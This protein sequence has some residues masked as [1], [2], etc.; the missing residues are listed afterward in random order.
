MGRPLGSKNKPRSQSE[1]SSRPKKRVNPAPA[2]T[3][4]ESEPAPPF[5]EDLNERDRF[6]YVPDTR[7]ARRPIALLPSDSPP[8]PRRY[9]ILDRI[10]LPN[11][12][13]EYILREDVANS[14]QGESLDSPQSQTTPSLISD[15]KQTSPLDS[16]TRSHTSASP[17]STLPHL[18]YDPDD[19]SLLRI[20]LLSIDRYVSQ[21]EVET[22]ENQ[23]FA[24]PKPED[25]P[26]ANRR[27]DTSSQGSSSSGRRSARPQEQV[28][29]K[30][31]VGRP[32]KKRRLME[33]VVINNA[34]GMSSLGGSTISGSEE[35]D[36]LAVGESSGSRDMDG[37]VDMLESIEHVNSDSVSE[38]EVENAVQ[39]FLPERPAAPQ[40]RR[41]P[42]S[43]S[44]R[45]SMA[46]PASRR[47]PIVRRISDFNQSPSPGKNT[48]SRATSYASAQ[49]SIQLS[50]SQSAGSLDN[51]ALKTSL[52][53]SP[54][55]PVVKVQKPM[56]GKIPPPQVEKTTVDSAK[57]L[58]REQFGGQSSHSPRSRLHPESPKRVSKPPPSLNQQAFERASMSNPARTF[59]QS[60]LNFPKA[61][62]AKPKSPEKPKSP[63]PKAKS[64][65]L[66]LFVQQDEDDAEEE[67]P[68]YE[69]SRI[70]SHH[71]NES[72]R[73]YRVAWVGFPEEE[74]T[75]LTEAELGG[76]KKLLKKYKKMVRKMEK[77]GGEAY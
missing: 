76:A 44:S 64:L 3:E 16:S 50:R 32:P 66:P 67:E 1:D 72:G 60:K 9:A 47:T 56:F 23:R 42:R 54:P 10:E 8:Q 18:D 77:R 63:P 45:S 11:E 24:N 29:E 55:A 15:L 38:S 35:S 19:P 65:D 22:Y 31:P 30:K 70:L 73:Y 57:H 33:A 27:S 74:S 49:S 14:T 48:R 53:P 26:F 75:Y 6:I 13:P 25:D 51:V 12:L 28:Q 61:V 62:P 4:E 34:M 69:V 52:Q 20:S 41:S 43:T 46:P 2:D 71:D 17:H 39:R 5:V 58:L 37:D 59:K 21:R 36:G 68:E 40:P 7:A